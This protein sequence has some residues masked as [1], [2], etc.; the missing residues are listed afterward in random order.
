MMGNF[1][2]SFALVPAVHAPSVLNEVGLKPV[3]FIAAG[4]GVGLGPIVN[5]HMILQALLCAERLQADVALER[6]LARVN[7][8]MRAQIGLLGEAFEA[9]GA[10][11]RS[12]AGVRAPVDDQLVGGGV[13]LTAYE[14]E[15]A[16][17]T[18][19]RGLMRAQLTHPLAADVAEGELASRRLLLL[20][21]R[22]LRAAL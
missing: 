12:L 20:T 16:A 15:M 8:H 19:M 4:A 17:L 5:V 6:L 9:E 21:L 1:L 11:V 18:A 22:L 10:L 2:L 13:E 7:A 14:A 3:L